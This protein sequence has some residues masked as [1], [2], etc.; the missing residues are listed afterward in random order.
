MDS[1]PTSAN[2]EDHVSMATFAARRLDE[3]VTNSRQIVACELLA[4]A[5]G[6]DF[7]RPLKTSAPLGVLHAAVRE[8]VEF[9]TEDR[10]LAPDLNAI[11]DLILEGL[12]HELV[13]DV[14]PGLLPSSR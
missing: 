7:H 10:Y 2:Q 14:V 11:G 4:A 12:C 13:T 1:L 3:M 9:Y 6:V 5:Q 8:R